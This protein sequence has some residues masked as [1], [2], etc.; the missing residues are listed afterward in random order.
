MTPADRLTMG[1]TP[2]T[3][4]NG[5]RTLLGAMI[6]TGAVLGQAG[7]LVNSALA[8]GVT[9]L[10][11]AIHRRY[12]H[13]LD[14]RLTLWIAVAATVHAVGAFGPYDIH[15]GPWQWY[16]TVAHVIS[17]AF[18]AGVGYAI[19]AALDRGSSRFQFPPEFRFVV[20]LVFI[21]AV[22][23]AWEIVEFAVGGLATA[24]TGEEVL[25]QYGIDDTVFDLAFN[26]VA[27]A[28]VAI[29]GTEY[30]RGVATFLTGRLPG[31]PRT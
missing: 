30:F 2:G 22:G 10:P 12:G 31:L 9:M 21:L 11:L 23:V 24:I 28:I 17:A 27:A 26:A 3:S 6:V 4:V 20:I 16:D 25:I 18:I 7:P 29:W 19:V 8:L 5:L 14:P 1:V 15:S 13:R